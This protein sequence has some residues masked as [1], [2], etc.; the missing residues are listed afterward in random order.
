[1]AGGSRLRRPQI[2]GGR[3]VE[4]HGLAER[5]QRGAPEVRVAHGDARHDPPQASPQ[6]LVAARQ[7]VQLA[8]VVQRAAVEELGQRLLAPQVE[9]RAVPEG[10]RAFERRAHWSPPRRPRA[11]SSAKWR[12][13]AATCGQRSQG[14][15]SPLYEPSSTSARSSGAAAA[16]RSTTSTVTD[17]PGCGYRASM[18]RR[19]APKGPRGPA[20]A[21]DRPPCS[22]GSADPAH[23]LCHARAPTGDPKTLRQPLGGLADHQELVDHCATRWRWQRAR[24]SSSMR[25]QS[26]HSS[27]GVEMPAIG[28]TLATS[29]QLGCR[30]GHQPAD[31]FI[32]ELARGFPLGNKSPHLTCAFF[33]I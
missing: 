11:S 21:R 4:V 1:M 2:L 24:I 27:R 14:A 13:R 16:S 7:A 25:G 6:L 32:P 26:T 19:A 15:T 22:H 18:G 28:V 17:D 12:P 23:L 29:R 33:K 10:R 20:P 5:S 31:G 8:P 9:A 30:A 3:R